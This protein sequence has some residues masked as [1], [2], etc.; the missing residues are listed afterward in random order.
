MSEAT[1]WCDGRLMR[2]DESA[3]YLHP[4]WRCG[5]CGREFSEG[6]GYSPHESAT[7]IQE[8]PDAK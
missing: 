2:L 7:W 3:N 8:H 5:K 4:I 1:K 6:F